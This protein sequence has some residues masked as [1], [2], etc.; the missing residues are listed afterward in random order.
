MS[1]RT[2][3]RCGFTLV[4]LLVVI[5]IIGILVTLVIT[6]VQVA[7]RAAMRSK[8]AKYQKEIGTALLHYESRKGYFPGFI[9]TLKNRRV[10]WVV[11]IL[12]D[13][14]RK[15]LYDLW[16]LPAQP[17][18]V[19]IPTLVCPVDSD[20]LVELAPLT[21]VVNFNIFRDRTDPKLA[22]AMVTRTDM[23]AGQLTPMVSERVYTQALKVGPWTAITQQ[24]LT[25]TW[26][27]SGTLTN[28]PLS[29]GHGNGAHITF[30]DGHVDF[31]ADTINCA[32]YIAGP[33]K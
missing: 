12:E 1:T 9:N 11:T 26:P 31:V 3:N 2:G 22:T 18:G 25:F 21:Y 20:A 30:C 16:L 29:S 14:D 7:R 33:A 4:E 24:N 19:R 32:D 5:T 8:C 10:S 17:A 23:K 15:D 6:G 13:I 27:A 28:I